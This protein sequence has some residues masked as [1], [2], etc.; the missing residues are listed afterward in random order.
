[1]PQNYMTKAEFSRLCGISGAMVSKYARTGRLEICIL[2][3]VD[4]KASLKLLEGSLDEN[5]RRAAL[6]KLAGINVPE[7]TN[8]KGD[9]RSPSAKTEEIPPET[10]KRSTWNNQQTDDETPISWKAQR[11]RAAAKLAELDLEQRLGSLC[12]AREV[13]AAAAD[14]TATFFSE[15]ERR[16][17]IDADAFS[18]SL[19]LN[20]EQAKKLRILIADRDKEIRANFAEKMRAAAEAAAP[21]GKPASSV[22]RAAR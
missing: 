11:D 12:D 19:A 6:L 2:G 13:H 14:T 9:S 4:A 22:E 5:K 17:R 15:L 1:M 10:S 7:T 20:A 18:A 8:A 3:K 16:Q 21:K